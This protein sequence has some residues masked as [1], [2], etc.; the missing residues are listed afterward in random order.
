[1]KIS[2]QTHNKW[3]VWDCVPFSRTSYALPKY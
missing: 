1:M 3:V 2:K